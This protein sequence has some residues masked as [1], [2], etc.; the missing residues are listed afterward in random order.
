MNKDIK[1]QLE[2]LLDNSPEPYSD[3]IV[4]FN[5][6]RRQVIRQLL[7]AAVDTE[8]SRSML[9]NPANMFPPDR[10]TS[11]QSH[12]SPRS[13][14]DQHASLSANVA[15]RPLFKKALPSENNDLKTI[16]SFLSSSLVNQAVSK[17]RSIKGLLAKSQPHALSN[18][19]GARIMVRREELPKIISENSQILEG[20]YS[21]AHIH[22]PSIGVINPQGQDADQTYSATS[23]GLERTK[24]LSAWSAFGTRG[25]MRNGQPVRIAVLD[26]GVDPKHPDLEGKIADYAEFDGSGTLAKVGLQ[27]AR[28]SGRHGTHV[29]GTI[30]GGNASGGWIGMAPEAEVIAGLVLDGAKG[31]TLAQVLSGIDWAVQSKAQIINMSLGGLTFD[32]SVD[33]PYQRAIVDALINGVLVVTAIGN[34][35]H[36][37]SGPPGNDYFSLAVG[38]HDIR[39]RCAGFSAGRTHVL[40]ESNFIKDSFLPLVYTK[41]DVS[42]PGVAVKS[43]VPGNGW[44]TFNGTSMATPH[45]S[46]A[47]A[48]L[49]AATDLHSL[50][51][52][53]RAVTTK[54]IILGGVT[55]L[56][57]AGQDQR[58][59]YGAINVLKSVDEAIRRGFGASLP[60]Q[61]TS[62]SDTD[63][64]PVTAAILEK[65]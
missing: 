47:A 49:I 24:A 12:S 46:G 32:S 26:T 10:K 53:Q 15:R 29:T 9:V 34:D 7:E 39:R 23:W 22:A 2:E 14:R 41:P 61:A 1:R 31:G 19:S 4:Q 27:H 37:T 17:V 11:S 63:E 43:C 42:A 5:S 55:D 40:N 44:E 25:R 33:T 30:I 18:I 60:S 65:S 50:E 54:D 51:P 56:G 6:P 58:F 20:V 3:V 59:G 13:L 48:L 28:D 64:K 57:E 45:V 21:N 62:P 16:T 36:Q 35:G 8:T 38:A 52:A